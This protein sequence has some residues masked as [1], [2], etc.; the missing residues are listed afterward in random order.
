MSREALQRP[1]D[2]LRRP[3]QGAQELGSLQEW[4]TR[5][6]DRTTLL[7]RVA[8]VLVVA[9]LVTN[10]FT[11]FRSTAAEP[12]DR[13]WSLLLILLCSWP[14]AIFAVRDLW[15]RPRLGA[16]QAEL[17]AERGLGALRIRLDAQVQHLGKRLASLAPRLPE[18]E[19]TL[20]RAHGEARHRLE[21]LSRAGE[22]GGLE[23][24]GDFDTQGADP[25]ESVA[26]R[27][28][29]TVRVDAF[30]IALG[31]LEIDALLQPDYL[32][33]PAASTA[34]SRAFGLLQS[35]SAIPAARATRTPSPRRSIAVLP[36]TDLSPN[37]DQEYFSAG[38]AE[39]L[40][41]ALTRVEELRVI[42]RGS[43]FALASSEP[44]LVEIGRR[45]KVDTVIQGSIRTAGNRLRITVQM[46]STRDGVSLWS[47]QYEGGMDNLFD[48]QDE[49]TS[50]V[51][52]ELTR[53]VP[54]AT[55]AA[56][57]G[58]QTE[59][60]EAYHLY[61]KGRHFWAKRTAAD[62]RLSIDCFENAVAL[63]PGYALA[64]AGV[65]DAYNLLG[66]Y[67]A[68]P[69]QESFPKAKSAA[70][71]ALALDDGLAEAHCSLAFTK[72]LFDWDWRVAGEEFERTFELNPGYATAHHW[73]AEYLALLGRHDSAIDQSR[74]AL[75][76]DPLSLII[77]VVVGWTY[78]YARRYDE[79]IASLQETLLLGENF[80]PAEFWLGLAFERAGD[81]EQAIH[82]LRRATEHS[83]GSSM[84]LAA[85]GHHYAEVGAEGKA[86]EILRVLAERAEG[87]YVP[88]YHQASIRAGQGDTE[89]S[90]VDL[91]AAC[92]ARENWLV[93][94]NID[95]VWDCLRG[96]PRFRTLVEEVGLEAEGHAPVEEPE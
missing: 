10:L 33:S 31:N 67:D 44:D 62:L 37:G 66:Y 63:D 93:F 19:E 72:L 30:R 73:F 87:E 84:M 38:L 64:W 26:R 1:A 85:Q 27:E 39:E 51:V 40:I 58:R 4:I 86:E 15:L 54:A 8:I 89:G 13:W 20:A 60:L 29:L 25:L 21:R 56:V 69:P 81:S 92:H 55:A 75:A 22:V 46:V 45:L 11:A 91:E 18:L 34:M 3:V 76:L 57:T 61:L 68:A 32:S 6:R 79:A 36:F 9:I 12:I 78:Y 88:R 42:A 49:I 74:T 70:S 28:R 59:T 71:R 53:E 5:K 16:A 90:L 94:L 24:E 47:E 50:A 41:N 35:S 48:A 43:A 65:A 95:P 83:G 82:F 14:V 23:N 80:A 17:L 96:E 7:L 77:N 52:E 2:L